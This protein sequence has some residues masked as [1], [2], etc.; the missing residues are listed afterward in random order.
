[1]EKAHVQRSRIALVDDDDDLRTLLRHSLQLRGYEV[2]EFESTEQALGWNKDTQGIVDPPLAQADLLILDINLPGLSGIETIQLMKES[3]KLRR[4]PIAMLTA[5]KE[6]D[7]VLKCIKAGAS[8]YFVKPLDFPEVM[9]RIEKLLS[10]PTKTLA[11]TAQVQVAWNFQELLVRELKRAE[12]SNSPLSL[13]V[14]GIRRV[15]SAYQ[16]LT[17]DDIDREWTAVPVHSR[18]I[19]E[20]VEKFVQV[21]RR[22]LREYDLLV[23]FGN[24]EFAGIL[25]ETTGLGAEAVTRRIYHL[26]EQ[27]LAPPPLSRQERWV[28]LVGWAVF[29]QDGL[30]SLGL[31][32]K[33]ESSLGDEPPAKEKKRQEKDSSL[34]PKTVQCPGCGKHYTYPKIGSRR[35]APVGRETDLR[36]LFEDLDPLLYGVVACPSCGVG[37]FET[38]LK[39]LRN[40]EPPA[41]GWNYEP[42]EKDW[43][44]TRPTQTLVPEELQRNLSPPYEAWVRPG[45]GNLRGGGDLP[46]NLSPEKA[47]LEN[48]LQGEDLEVSVNQS[49][50]RHLLAA[51]TYR[52]AGASPLRRARLAHRIAWLYRMRKQKERENQYLS[53]ALDY[54]LTA[55]HFEDLADAKPN[56]LEILYLLGELSFRLGKDKE[57]VAIFEHLVRDPRLESKPSFLKMIRRRWY[58]ARHEEPPAEEG[59]TEQETP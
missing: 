59:N 11:K 4:I 52:L 56:E 3:P 14:G 17:T 13:L 42:R 58:E 8:D 36:L 10:D 55:F 31:F 9:R 5:H 50:D 18:E 57:A 51:Q 6:A 44:L 28:L 40:L 54:Y 34:F 19:R 26:F 48:C 39:H 30:D 20:L 46:R 22:G 41:F 1:L 24:G 25:P 2:L 47:R 12:R 38:D 16:K 29:P 32:T 7:V 37:S 21:C 45:E 33:A 49:L 23:P 27:E 53:E 43:A 15:S 35:L